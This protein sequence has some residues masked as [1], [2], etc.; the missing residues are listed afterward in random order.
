MSERTKDWLTGIF[1]VFMIMTTVLAISG[2]ANESLK[3]TDSQEK[4]IYLIDL[5]GVIGSYEIRIVE[6]DGCEYLVNPVHRGI[7]LA[8]KGNC[9]F[10]L[11]R[12]R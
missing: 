8:H 7:G 10:C 4:G 3:V 11:E 2:C 9:K 1:C 5:P 12:K 6:I